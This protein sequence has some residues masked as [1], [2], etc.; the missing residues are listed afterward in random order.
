MLS[1]MGGF[2]LWGQQHRIHQNRVS[3]HGLPLEQGG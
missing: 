2:S 3:I 1:G